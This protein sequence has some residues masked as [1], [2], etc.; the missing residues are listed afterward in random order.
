[1]PGRTGD[2]RITGEQAALR[3]VATLAAAA[4][5]PEQLFAAVTEEAGRLLGA[6]Y[7]TM[8]RYDPDG[9][10]TVLAAWEQHRCCLPRRQPGEAGR[11]ERA[12]AGVPDPPA[13]ADR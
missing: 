6:D 5:A 3:R 12:D 13:G 11:A 4:A 1:L 2:D 9:T 8:A 10:R 7:T